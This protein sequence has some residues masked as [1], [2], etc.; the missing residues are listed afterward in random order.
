MTSF[1][2]SF[3]LSVSLLFLSVSSI[4]ASEFK[5]RYTTVSYE[6]DDLL[7]KFNRKISLGGLSYL[8][9]N[10]KNI[11]LED[12]IRNKI[13]AVFEKSESILDMF[14]KNLQFTIV[15]LASE[16]DVQG[17]YR[18]KYGRKS[19]FISFYSPGNKTVYLSV[20]DVRLGVLAHELAHVILDN[21]FDVPPPVKIHELLSQYVETHIED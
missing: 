1:L 13:D 11:T 14:P 4:H 7:R 2:F 6:R 17:I 9:R 18:N 16:T 21:Y 20:N 12:E 8:V 15:L 19:E 5:T 10:K 3:F